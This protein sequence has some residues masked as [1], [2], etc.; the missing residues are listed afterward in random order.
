M[1]KLK[2][3][4]S[5]LL[6]CCMICSGG[7][8]VQAENTEEKE[9]QTETTVIDVTD[10]GADPSGKEDSALAVQDAIEAAKKVDGPVTIEFPKGEYHIY[11]EYAPK[12]DLYV[13]N[14]VGADQNYV[15][16]TIGILLEDMK[17]VTIEGNDSLFMFHGKMTVLSTIDCENITFQDFDFDFQVPT[18][19]DV[20]VEETGNDGNKDYAVVYVP[21]CYEYEIDGNNINWLSDVSPY[22]GKRYW[23]ARNSLGYTQVYDLASG[24]TKRTGNG[25]FS[26]VSGIEDL[27]NHRLKFSYNSRS[28]QVQPG[29]CYQMRYTDRDVPGTFIWQSKDIVLRNIG[30]RYLHG[31]GMVGQ[32][33]ENITYDNIEFKTPENSGRTTAGFADFVQMSGC[34]GEMKINNCFFSNAHDDPI[35]V[36]GTFLQVVERISDRKFKVRYMHNQTAGFPNFYVGDEVEFMTKGN[37]V[38]VENSVATVT[39]VEGPDDSSRTDIVITLDRDMPAEIGVNTHVVENITYTPSVTITNCVFQAI[40]T[41]GILVTTRKPIRI[42]NNYF[43]SMG[44]AGIYISNDAAGWYESGPTRDVVIRNNVFRKCGSADGSATIF[45]DPTNSTV[46]P[47]QPVHQNVLIEDNTFYMQN[48]QVLN[49]KSVSNLV[50]RNNQIYRYDPNVEITVQA[51][52]Q[53]LKVGESE[54]VQ[55]SSSGT[56]LGTGLYSFNGC[57]GVELSG[58]QYDAG[59]NQRASVYGGMSGDAKYIS[60]GENEDVIVGSDNRKDPVGTISYRSSDETIATVSGDGTVKGIGDGVAEITA[61]TEIGGREFAS[62]PLRF[63]VGDAQ[64]EDLPQSITI[65]SEGDT[66]TSLS[67]TMQFTAQVLPDN[68]VEKEVKWTV[69]DPATGEESSVAS[70][71]EDGLLQPQLEG[72]V[73]VTGSTING[74]SASKLVVISLAASNELK[75]SWEIL[76][77]DKAYWKL[78]EEKDSFHIT[79]QYGSVWSTMD[80][81]KNRVLTA[82]A[83]D[84][85]NVT[86]TVKMTGKTKSGWEEGGLMFYKDA[87][88]YIAVQ[89][90]HAAGSP[91]INVV[92]E[93]NGSPSELGGGNTVA[94]IDSQDIYLKIE[95]QGNKLTGSYSADGQTWKVLR[96][97][98][99]SGLGTDYKIGF[100]ACGDPSGGPAAEFEF[101]ELTI[102]G[103]VYGFRNQNEAP[104]ASDLT[105]SVSKTAPGQEV[106]LSYTYEDPEEDAEGATQVFWLISENENE[107]GELVSGLSGKTITVP[108]ETEGKWLRAAVVPVDAAGKPGNIAY[109]PAIL[110]EAGTRARVAR[111]VQNGGLSAQSHLAEA[112]VS[113][114]AFAEFAPK[115]YYYL[116]TA[117][118]DVQTTDLEFTACDADADIQVL[119]NSRE[120]AAGKGQVQK[121][122]VELKANHNIFEV[123]VTAPDGVDKSYYRFIVMRKGYDNSQLS[124]IQINGETFV[125]FDPDT[126]EYTLVQ[127]EAGSLQVSAEQ[128]HPSSSLAITCRADRTEAN[129]AV[130]WTQ[131]G[132]NK[133]VF[134][135]KPDTNAP[136]RYYTV[137]VK[138][139]KNDDSYLE[140]LT[141]DQNVTLNESFRKDQYFY[142]ASVMSAEANLYLTAQDINARLTVYADGKEVHSEDNTLT[143]PLHFYKGANAVVIQVTA[144]DG[145]QRAYAVTVT[146]ESVEYAND[147][148]WRDYT[149]GWGSIQIDKN[150]S[151]NTLQLKD[152]NGNTVYYDRGIG[153]HANSV[154]HFDLDGKG[155]ERF[156]A[157]VG[158]DASQNGRGSVTFK[159]EK[160]GVEVF[161]SGELT[162]VSAQKEVDIDLAGASELTLIADMGANDGNDHSDWAD[163]KF[164]TAELA[165]RPEENR[166]QI[167][168]AITGEGSLTTNA[169]DGSLWKGDALLAAAVPQEGQDLIRLTVNGKEVLCNAQN[170]YV[171]PNLSGDVTV[172]AEFGKKP[173]IPEDLDD[174]L[175]QAEEAKIAAEKAKLQAEK[176]K[177]EALKAKEDAE[178]ARQAAEEAKLAAEEAERKAKELA[179]KAGADSEAAQAAKREAEAK[180]ALAESAKQQA[181]QAAKE[182]KAAESAAKA[183]QA[184]AES[185]KAKAMAMAAEAEAKAAEAEAARKQAEAERLA[186]EAA[187]KQAEA[188]REAARKALEEAL[189]AQK[190]AEE[191]M[192]AAKQAKEELAEKLA[193][194]KSEK[195]ARVSLKSVKRSSAGNLKVT[196]KKVKDADGYQVQYAKNSKFKNAVTKKT[197]SKATLTLKKLTKGQKY[198]VRVR[199]FKNTDNGKI[200][201]AYSKVKK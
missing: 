131:P 109:G 155:Y 173:D 37:M 175:K 20:T 152:E 100:L 84:K 11:P 42:E 13:S 133:I 187:R 110:A 83:G 95:K 38:P 198:Y 59:L 76:N 134:T 65:S 201:G 28:S 79:T 25:L 185:L 168:T 181:E 17:D 193:A 9:R 135:V 114:V 47:D 149:I 8:F 89:R 192:A 176:A 105:C 178:T 82:F 97:V 165:S 101:S 53:V 43:D 189:E 12:R 103:E 164:T 49:A 148:N 130:V 174:L 88:N 30:A 169:V 55:T 144:A 163:A 74:K 153:T 191:A 51:E 80:S 127:Q 147:T 6:S 142:T 141:F 129:Q 1:R 85:E 137:T 122:Q 117:D 70:I 154:I 99:N 54:N 66:I 32:F 39:E 196:W 16:K 182:A 177:E 116:A 151:G 58:N 93:E 23:T 160:D 136:N 118:A 7:I 3:A 184:E 75:E 156:H 120:I 197:G 33:S 140:K 35:N 71:N 179:E 50:F 138:V 67:Q 125:G 63:Y 139:P 61:Y 159:V 87:N 91:N 24:E 161:N 77:E 106:T 73:L 44:M 146:G 194:L 26:S 158:V 72:I 10:F 183:A 21:E 170:Q 199:A 186:A 112:S 145:S 128:A 102:N 52:K 40:P 143:V 96:E 81:A 150:I 69:T 121:A 2:K 18:V 200:Y 188:E 180:A 195:P 19:I 124:S 94:D 113:G 48:R 115:T 14:T 60:I 166:C 4:L 31:F 78:D 34:K 108:E 46:N 41:R 36:H 45:F 171:L 162:S 64:S 104:K 98:T 107:I 29:I 119:Y 157:F 15:T 190:K 92:S 123:M 172:E 5:V 56:S 132:V 167:T 57:K 126:T 90:K 68:A 111:A 22:T 86:A 27:G 62:A